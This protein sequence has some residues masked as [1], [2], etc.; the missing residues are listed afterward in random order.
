MIG[1]QAFAEAGC[2]NGRKPVVG[3]VKEM[4]IVAKF[5]TQR[6]KQLGSVK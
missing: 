5:E 3:I 1:F 2:L 4:Y 6:F